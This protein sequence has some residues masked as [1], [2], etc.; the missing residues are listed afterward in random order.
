[1]KAGDEKIFFLAPK[2][3][4]S[5]TNKIF[6]EALKMETRKLWRDTFVEQK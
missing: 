3:T 2:S 5:A 1:V 6:M 4:I